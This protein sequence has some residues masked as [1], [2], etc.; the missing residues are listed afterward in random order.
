[1]KETDD[2]SRRRFLKTGSLLG[3]AAAFSP[4]IIAE[5]FSNS[6][7]NQMGNT[8]TQTST[9]QP[10]SEQAADKA[11]IRPFHWNF[12]DAE[13]AD[14][15]RRVNATKW[16]D[17][18]QVTDASQGVQLATMQKL[19]RY[20]GRDYDWRKGEAKLKAVPHFV[21]EIDGLDNSLHSRAL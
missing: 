17:R 12:P 18:E 1:M 2:R 10:A 4:R 8:V 21:T 7:T 6:K 14:L 13:V 20:W 11:A 16:P 9:A 19:A 5:A 3:L 15:R